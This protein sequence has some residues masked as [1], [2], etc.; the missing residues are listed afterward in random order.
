[1]S[2]HFPY[3]YQHRDPGAAGLSVEGHRLWLQ[4]PI[5]LALWGEHCKVKPWAVILASRI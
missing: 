1:M 2:T 3:L 5:V 4:R